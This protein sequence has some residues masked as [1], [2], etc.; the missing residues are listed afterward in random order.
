[1]SSEGVMHICFTSDSLLKSVNSAAI[2]SNKITRYCVWVTEWIY[3]VACGAVS[4]PVQLNHER[5]WR[6]SMGGISNT[7]TVAPWGTT[8][9]TRS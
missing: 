1:M 5:P 8:A 3:M 4:V 6:I 7:A 9:T 2:P